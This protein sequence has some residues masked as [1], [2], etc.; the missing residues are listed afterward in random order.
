MTQCNRTSLEFSSLGRKKIVAD[1]DGGDLTS[2]A[3]MLLLRE[4][5]RQVGLIQ[6]IDQAIPDP[7]N[8]IYV[9]H[10]QKHM[11]TQRIFAMALGHE[12]LNDHQELRVDPLMQLATERGID[13]ETPMASIATLHRLENRVSRKSLAAINEAFVETFIRSFE[14]QEPPKE[15]VLDFDATDD[16]VHGNQDQRFFHGYYDSYCFLPLYVF[17]GRHLLTAYLR[18]ANID[19]AKHAWA[20]LALLVK[21]LREQWPEVKIIFRAD[22]GFC[23]WRIM[24][25]CDR[26]AVHYIIGIGKNRILLRNAEP[27]MTTAEDDYARTCEKQRVFGAFL[28][29]AGTWDKL[30]R[31][32]VKAE[33]LSQGENTRF[34]VT[35]L[36]GVPQSLYDDLYCARGEAE[37]RIK[38]QQLGLFADRTSCHDFTANQFRV[39]LSAAAYVLIEHVRRVGLAGTELANAQ[40]ST[41]RL[42]LLKIGACIR[43]SVRRVL[44]HLAS[45]F[46]RKSLF[47]EVLTRLM[48]PAYPPALPG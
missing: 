6:A 37:N 36:E 25:W 18:P 7:R 19:A 44:L 21:R 22:A 35:N 3:G 33:R 46:P 31:V 10:Q 29:A 43:C 2:D 20:I 13:P 42:K 4:A 45:G 48:V 15:L 41:I 23:R 28:Y 24:R 30:R 5:E 26:H 9:Q 38:E 47:A 27:W 16:S 34:V 11:L 32:I 12:D 17:C 14:G 40:V 39:L 1:F 8:P